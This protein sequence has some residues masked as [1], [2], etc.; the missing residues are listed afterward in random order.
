MSQNLANGVSFYKTPHTIQGL[1]DL[2]FSSFI[3]GQMF[4]I[5]CM[6]IIPRFVNGRHLFE[7]RERD[8]K[9]YSWVVFLA[10]NI[11]VE[12]C[13]LTLISVLVY[14][15]W[16][17]PTGL[18]ENGTP[19]FGTS[20]RGGLTHLLLLAFLLWAGTIAHVFAAVMEQASTAIQV[21]TL[22]FWLSLTFCGY[23]ANSPNPNPLACLLNP[24]E[25]IRWPRVIPRALADR[26]LLQHPGSTDQTQRLLDV[27]VPR[28]PSDLLSR[29]HCHCGRFRSARAV[30]RRGAAP[31]S[32]P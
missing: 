14:A 23:V 22:C 9:L 2:L 21:A 20:E 18:Y 6:V 17:Y 24:L 32:P 30:L 29:G 7:S 15:C 13:W 12:I 3:I 31:D 16:Y 4:S 1:I 11:I 25:H 5:L 28:V 10:S 26:R 27:H 19:A 8:S